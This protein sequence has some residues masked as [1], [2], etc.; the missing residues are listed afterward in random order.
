MQF[1]N[2]FGGLDEVFN[3]SHPFLFFI[4]DETTGTILFV[5]KYVHPKEEEALSEEKPSSP[6]PTPSSSS[7]PKPSK[8]RKKLDNIPKWY[9]LKEKKI[10]SAEIT[11]R[12]ITSQLL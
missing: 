5:G 4:E 3:A 8:E 6:S 1:V 11:Q 10:Y 7:T 12:Q 9:Q 2:K